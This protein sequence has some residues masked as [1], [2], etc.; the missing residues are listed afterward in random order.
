MHIYIFSD[1]KADPSKFPKAFLTSPHFC[2]EIAANKHCII[3]V[4]KN[5]KVETSKNY[6][7]YSTHAHS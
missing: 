1:Q 3:N 6:F 2:H 4:K 7:F 5:L